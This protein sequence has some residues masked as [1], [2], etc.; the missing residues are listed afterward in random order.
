[1]F[2]VYTDRITIIPDGFN[3]TIVINEM[4]VNKYN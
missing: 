4:F 2:T 1:M 3:K